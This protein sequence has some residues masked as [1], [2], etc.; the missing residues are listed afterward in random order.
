MKV[1]L[2]ARNVTL[3]FKRMPTNLWDAKGRY[4]TRGA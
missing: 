1:K 3:N 4:L 2:K